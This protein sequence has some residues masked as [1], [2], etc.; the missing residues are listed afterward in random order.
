MSETERRSEVRPIKQQH[1]YAVLLKT[2]LTSPRQVR[3]APPAG[4][5]RR[6]AGM[7]RQ[8][9]TSRNLPF[10]YLGVPPEVA[11]HRTLPLFPFCLGSRISCH[12]RQKNLPPWPAIPT[13]S[14]FPAAVDDGRAVWTQSVESLGSDLA[15]RLLRSDPASDNNSRQR[16]AHFCTLFQLTFRSGCGGGTPPSQW[17]YCTFCRLS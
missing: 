1:G 7:T 10:V 8:T 13:C 17:R 15:V 3:R 5:E 6:G 16:I 12:H 14:C 2:E 9:T 11:H 4:G